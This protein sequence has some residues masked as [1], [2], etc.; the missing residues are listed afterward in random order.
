[1]GRLCLS[2]ALTGC[3]DSFLVHGTNTRQHYR[4]NVLGNEATQMRPLASAHVAAIPVV[5]MY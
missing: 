3:C 4:E 5:L 2:S 1:M